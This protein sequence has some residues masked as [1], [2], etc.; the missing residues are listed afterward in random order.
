MR[1]H[2]VY[3]SSLCLLLLEINYYYSLV[4][5]RVVVGGFVLPLYLHAM[6]NIINNYVCILSG[7]LLVYDFSC[8]VLY[9]IRILE[10]K[11]AF[12]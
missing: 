7:V 2:F 10:M 4:L 8:K 12:E 5:V 3:L 9:L 11:L 1:V 6:I